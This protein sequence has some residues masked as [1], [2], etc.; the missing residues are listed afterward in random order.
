[1]TNQP[2]LLLQPG[3]FTDEGETPPSEKKRVQGGE[4]SNKVVV[5]AHVAGNDEV[6]AQVA[7][8]HLPLGGHV[9]DVTYGKG[10]FWK[11][12]P[13]GQYRLHFSDIDAKIDLDPVHKVAV[14]TG[15]DCRDLPFDDASLD[16]LVLDPPYMEGLY[17]GKTTHLAGHGTHS[18][19]RH[20][21]SNGQATP[22]T[23]KAPKWHDAVVDLYLKAG[24]EANR[25]LR[26]EGTFIVKCQDEVSANRQRLTHVEL[27]SAFESL[28]FYTKD[29]F[30]VVRNNRPGISRLKRQVHAR[31]NHSYF[32][33]FQKSKMKV[34]NVISLQQGSPAS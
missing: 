8:L 4:P 6:F 19:F 20:A 5:S 14:K 12:V 17:R 10:V 2:K 7:L 15:I 24:I 22:S 26:Q 33:V 27:I 25:V 21:Y 30:V 11:Q 28:G 32:L 3:E 23:K 16:G 34:S 9:A 18:T 13:Q 1:M 29:L 31:K